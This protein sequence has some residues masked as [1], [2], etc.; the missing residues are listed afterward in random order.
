MAQQQS[1]IKELAAK[2]VFAAL[3]TLQEMGGQAPGREVVA[4]VDM[5]VSTGG[6]TPDAKTTTRSSHV[7]I[8]LVDLDRFITLWQ[9]FYPKLSDEDKNLLSL[10]PIYFFSPVV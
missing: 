4:E 7:H 5:F 6:F 9:E 3:K 2:L 10:V 8:E 1:K